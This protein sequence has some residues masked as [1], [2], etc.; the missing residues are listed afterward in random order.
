MTYLQEIKDKFGLG[1]HE[2][3]QILAHN[4][5]KVF[6]FDLAAL[7]TVADRIGPDFDDESPQQ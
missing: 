5:A 7:Q 1:R 3:D 4:P 6:G 2:M